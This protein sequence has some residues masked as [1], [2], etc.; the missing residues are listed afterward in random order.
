M[1]NAEEVNSYVKESMRKRRDLFV[2]T[3]HSLFPILIEKIKSALYA[4][5]PLSSMGVQNMTDSIAF[6]ELLIASDNIAV[7]PGTAFG[8]DG[9]VRFAFSESEENIYQALHVLKQAINRL[10]GETS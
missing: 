2:S 3:Y 9:Y 7:L 10:V 4:F 6:S 8:V 1:E 5:V